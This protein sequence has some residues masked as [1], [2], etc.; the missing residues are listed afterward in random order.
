M[1]RKQAALTLQFFWL[2][3][4]DER[5]LIRQLRDAQY[6]QSWQWLIVRK[7]LAKL[8]LGILGIDHLHEL[9]MVHIERGFIQNLHPN[10]GLIE[11]AARPRLD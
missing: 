10:D 4:E 1:Q 9:L 6:L 8:E 5:T 3:E 7:L 11:I 2:V